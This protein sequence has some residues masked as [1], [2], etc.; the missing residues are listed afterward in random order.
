MGA[1]PDE[2]LA[3]A[4]REGRPSRGEPVGESSTARARV[5]ADRTISAMRPRTVQRTMWSVSAQPIVY[6][7]TIR[8]VLTDTLLSA[9]RPLTATSNGRDTV[10]TGELPDQ[11][12]LYG[13]LGRFEA[14]GLE[15][16]EMNRTG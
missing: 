10:L 8:G 14:L 15:L 2:H 4:P 1:P 9:F 3:V 11:A 12:A 13:I 6:R 7:F 16:L 5:L